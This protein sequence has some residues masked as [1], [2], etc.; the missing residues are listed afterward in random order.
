[1]GCYCTGACQRPPYVCGASY[2][3][4]AQNYPSL[5]NPPLPHPYEDRM[6][7]F[8]QEARIAELEAL[9]KRLEAAVETLQNRE[10]NYLQH[11]RCSR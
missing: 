9:I 3:P 6:R 2:Y 11:G 7:D 8:K 4:N 10:Q 5:P 1:M